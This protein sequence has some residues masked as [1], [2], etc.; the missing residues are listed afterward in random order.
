MSARG[1]AGVVVTCAACIACV[2][3]PIAAGAD[4]VGNAERPA[5]PSAP[6][7]DERRTARDLRRLASAW[8]DGGGVFGYPFWEKAIE[9]YRRTQ[10]S[11]SMLQQYVTGYR[12]RMQL[13]CD[14]LDSTDAGE[15]TA[16]DVKELVQDACDRRVDAL[17]EQT[18]WLDDVVR[19]AS[20]A[21]APEEVD[22]LT[23]SAQEHADTADEQLQVSYR[24]TRRAMDLAQSALDEA[25]LPR[26]A[27][28]A[29][30]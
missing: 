24:D 8:A 21:L 18:K 20:P 3:V 11:A 13:G 7:D 9:R 25:G 12:D 30:L 4:A 28:D 1:R 10:I 5:A 27:E 16:S 29:F 23:A 22:S 26:I 15:G 14:L 6:T 2:A 19:S 17:R